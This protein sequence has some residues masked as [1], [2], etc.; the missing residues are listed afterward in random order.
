[1]RGELEGDDGGGY[2]WTELV[3]PIAAQ[4]VTGAENARAPQAFYSIQVKISWL[5][6]GRPR[7]M[8]LETRRLGSAPAGE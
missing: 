6:A 3:K 2:R 7:S 5:A 1:M 8:V 4:P